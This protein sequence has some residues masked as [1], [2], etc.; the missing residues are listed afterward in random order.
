MNGQLDPLLGDGLVSHNHVG[1][2]VYLAI[3]DSIR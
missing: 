3:L 2:I 1:L